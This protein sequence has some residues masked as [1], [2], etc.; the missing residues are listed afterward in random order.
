MGWDYYGYKPYVPVAQRRAQAAKEVAK[1]LK[2][3]QAISPVRIEGRT[4]T[5][6]FWGRAWCA[7][8]ESYSDY[9]NRLPRGRTYVRNGSVVHLK[10]EKGRI[11]S[12][13]SGSELYT[14]QIEIAALPKPDWLALKKQSAGKIGTLV[15]LLKGKLSN[16]MME[17]VTGREHG[18]FPKPRE[19]KMRCSCPDG[20]SMCK[21]IAA[22][23]Y[24]VGHRLDSSPELLFILRGVDHLELIEQA[25][26][27]AP[28]GTSS[29]APTIAADDLGAIFDIEIDDARVPH[30]QTT[31]PAK[32]A[33]K[34]AATKAAATIPAKP[35][36][37][38]AAT[39][40]RAVKKG[41]AT[42]A[43]TKAAA[44]IPAKPAAK[45]A[46]TKARAVK[47]G[48]ATKKT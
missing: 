32:P 22:T 35:A 25:I 7:N 6:T 21:H 37:K 26:P 45:Q 13:V 17:L 2:N 15:E 43:A 34:Q 46:A 4:I 1:R 19:I 30:A 39:K 40:A 42:K 48:S 14:I 24:G 11:E 18:L 16:A 3:G 5:S 10:I 47:K 23:M 31:I 44:T 29:T 28:L 38:Q 27:T 12:L 20:A 9:A 36:A 8:L 41:S 33:A